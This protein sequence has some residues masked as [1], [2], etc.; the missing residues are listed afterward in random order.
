MGRFRCP[1]SHVLRRNFFW[2]DTVLWPDTLRPIP[3][4]VI[5]NGADHIVRS[6]ERV[7]SS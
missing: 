2:H 4:L 1:R 3:T 5:L 6:A 7:A